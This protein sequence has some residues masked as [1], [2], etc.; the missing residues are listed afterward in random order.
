MTRNPASSSDDCEKLFCSI[1]HCCINSWTNTQ[2]SRCSIRY[3]VALDVAECRGDVCRNTSSLAVY[4]LIDGRMVST[5]I[6]ISGDEARPATSGLA[7]CT[8]R[9]CAADHW[10]VSATGLR[11]TSP[12]PQTSVPRGPGPPRSCGAMHW[13]TGIGREAQRTAA[14]C[15]RRTGWSGTRA[16]PARRRI[17]TKTTNSGTDALC[18]FSRLLSSSECLRSAVI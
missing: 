7:V 4:L 5:M 1:W 12:P 3:A 16:R 18:T 13:N 6:S 8:A 14:S 11:Q 10:F 2:W 15:N 17:S 9:N